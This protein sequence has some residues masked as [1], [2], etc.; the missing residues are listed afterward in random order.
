VCC[1]LSSSI[2]Q[3]G[4][5][6]EILVNSGVVCSALV[7][8]SWLRT[9]GIA[10]A[11]SLITPDQLPAPVPVYRPL[12]PVYV[13]PSAPVYQ[14]PDYRPR[15]YTP[16]A[17]TY[18]T[19]A[20]IVVGED[21]KY[22]GRMS[23]NPYASDSVSNPYGQYGSRY[24]ADS[25]NNPYGKYGSPYSAQSATNPYATQ[26]P[27]LVA[28]RTGERLGRLSANPYAPDSTA[29]PYSPAGSPYSPTS[30]N[31]PYSPYYVPPPVKKK[32]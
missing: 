15:T 7:T 10:R 27:V 24:S 22:L 14:A 17:S 23:A 21:G 16:P 25:V 12:T 26:A 28:P 18:G 6:A 30:I 29:N 3:G 9:N 20:P 4:R 1:S 11:E 5:D 2:L 13:P 8:N 32:Q 31:N 19:A